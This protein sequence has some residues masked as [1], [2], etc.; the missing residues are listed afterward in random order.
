MSTPLPSAAK[1]EAQATKDQASSVP[2]RPEEIRHGTVTEPDVPNNFRG[3]RGWWACENCDSSKYFNRRVKEWICSNC[4]YR[5]FTVPKNECPAEKLRRK[6]VRSRELQ[7]GK[8]A[9]G[10]FW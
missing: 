10:W 3:G 8:S 1:L 5:N 7:K 9:G 6:V 2:P 4:Q